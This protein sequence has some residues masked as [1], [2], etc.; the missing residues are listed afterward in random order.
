LPRS[1]ADAVFEIGD[2]RDDAGDARVLALGLR[3]RQSQRLAGAVI[4]KRRLA[5]LLVENGERVAVG[6]PLGGA[7][8]P[9]SHQSHQYLEHVSLPVRAASF[10]RR[11][12]MQDTRN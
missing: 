3:L 11:S 2:L 5:H 1:R 6:Q 12:Q 7:G 8:R 9:P 10:E 4:A